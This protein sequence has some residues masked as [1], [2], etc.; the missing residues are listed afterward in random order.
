MLPQVRL[1]QYR[2]HFRLLTVV[3]VKQRDIGGLKKKAAT[4]KEWEF[5][6]SHFLL[7]EQPEGDKARF[8]DNV[9]MVYSP[10]KG[11]NVQLVIRRDVQG[12]KVGDTGRNMLHAG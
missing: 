3:V 8:L 4:D 11:G 6:L 9:H 10:E 7:Q 5:L 1:L 2:L 12:I